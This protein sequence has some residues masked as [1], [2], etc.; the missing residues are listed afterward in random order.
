[1]GDGKRKVLVINLTRM[2]DIV[3]SVPL[4]TDL[5]SGGDDL[6]ISYLAVTSYSEICR[7]IHQ[8]DRLIPFDFNSSV[9]VSKEAIR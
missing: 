3:Q 7:Y 9:A 5:K 6:H 1:M 4:L 8:I 2:G